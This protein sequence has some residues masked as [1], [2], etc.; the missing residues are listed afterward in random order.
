MGEDGY[1]S[2]DQEPIVPLSEA[3]AWE[4]LKSQRVGRLATSVSQQPEIFPVNFVVDGET[5]VFR[6]AA[7]SKLLELATNSKVAFEVDSWDADLGGWS[8]VTTGEAERVDAFGEI[9][10]LETLPLKPWVPTVKTN[11][12]KVTVTS[13][14][15]RKFTFG[16][17][18]D[19]Y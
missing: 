3:E 15:A 2:D 5:I 9:E 1:M 10:R 12:V 18:P 16:E 14:N 4:L 19:I 8:V 17:E 13:I 11:F 6:T 7:G